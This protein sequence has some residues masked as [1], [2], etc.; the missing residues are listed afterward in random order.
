MTIKEFFSFKKNRFFWINLVAILVVICFAFLI[1]LKWLDV[2]TRHGESVTVPDISGMSVKDAKKILKNKSLE[3]EISDSMYVKEKVPGI[4]LDQRPEQGQRVKEGRIVHL[5]INTL[6]VPQMT[7]P[8]VADNSSVRQAQA[9]LLAAGFR[10]TENEFITG[11]KDWVY[12]VKY[13]GRQLSINEKVPAGATLTLLVG[14]GVPE[15]EEIDSL[16]DNSEEVYQR[17]EIQPVEGAAATEDPW[18]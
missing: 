9:K 18:F 3:C 16:Y 14:D 7:V 17:E 12:G 11:E 10:L 13:N 5:T 1:V 8:D 2:Y 6:N 15:P 4:I